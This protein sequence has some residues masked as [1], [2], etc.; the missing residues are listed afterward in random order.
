[1]IW[2]SSLY[3]I[4]TVCMATVQGPLEAMSAEDFNLLEIFYSGGNYSM[5]ITV[6]SWQSFASLNF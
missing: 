1:M 5:S 6:Y 2:I 4:V 3:E